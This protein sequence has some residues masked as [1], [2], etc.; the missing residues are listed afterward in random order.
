MAVWE[1]LARHYVRAGGE[2]EQLRTHSLGASAPSSYLALP[3]PA[4]SPAA[5]VARISALWLIR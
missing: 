5:V 4:F 2:R 1:D 3:T